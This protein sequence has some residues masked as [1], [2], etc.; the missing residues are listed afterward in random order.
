MVQRGIGQESA[1]VRLGAVTEG[2]WRGSLGREA[3]LN[4]RHANGI[5]GKH[6]ER[7]AHRASLWAS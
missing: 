6:T 4:M 5:L 3:C 7:E 1:G 2:W